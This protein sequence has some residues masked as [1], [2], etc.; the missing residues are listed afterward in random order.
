MRAVRY[1]S[2]V[3]AIDPALPCR[4]CARCLEGNTNLCPRIAFS[5]NA[6]LDGGLCE[7]MSWPT[8]AVVPLPDGMTA[9][10]AAMLEPL[11]VAVH[12]WDLG[13]VKLG[14][15]V[16]IGDQVGDIHQFRLGVTAGNDNMERLRLCPHYQQHH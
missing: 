2:R 9:E 6:G 1:A 10:D 7:V 12:A 3:V 16:R 8:H 13:H 11:G 5:G 4:Q 15:R 14:D